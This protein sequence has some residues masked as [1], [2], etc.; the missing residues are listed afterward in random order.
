M[1]FITFKEKL[2]DFS[3]FSVNDIRMVYPRFFNQRLVEWQKKG[4]IKKIVRK[5]YIFSDTEIN[6]QLLFLTANKIYKPSYV[7][8]E[9]ALAYHGL[10][11]ESVYKIT[12]ATTKKT[13]SFNTPL[14]KLSYHTIHKK[15][16][17]GYKLMVYKKE[18]YIIAAPE[19]A[20]LDF[21]YINEHIKT[22][23]D[24]L[25]LRINKDRINGVIKMPVLDEY[26][27]RF[28]NRVLERKI[29]IFKGCIEND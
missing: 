24:V 10:I 17:F 13:Y 11:P 21:F 23:N 19:K 6:E 2:K 7:S 12:S 26:L 28:Q 22:K 29:K 16:F 18:N 8:F 14:G 1:N 25:E 9:S 27:S 20:L 4:Y 5:Y 3:V 15:Y